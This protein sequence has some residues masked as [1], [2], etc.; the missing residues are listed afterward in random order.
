MHTAVIGLLIDA[1]QKMSSV[2]IFR[3][4][5]RSV[6]P[7]APM[8]RMRSLVAIRVTMPATSPL[9]TNS[10]I[11]GAMAAKRSA[12][13]ADSNGV[14]AR[15]KKCSLRIIRA[16]LRRMFDS[17]TFR[18]NRCIPLLQPDIILSVTQ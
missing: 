6:L 3:S 9:S 4:P 18:H 11:R 16:P 7:A 10:C 15:T 2:R 8:W 13:W 14:I 5:A 1:I 12:C 17:T